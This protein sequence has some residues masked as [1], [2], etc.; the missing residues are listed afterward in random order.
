MHQDIFGIVNILFQVI[1]LPAEITCYIHILSVIKKMDHSYCQC[2]DGVL[3]PDTLTISCAMVSD[4]R[5][6]VLYCFCT[7]KEL[8]GVQLAGTT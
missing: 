6:S 8:P 2:V 5:T 3:E 1:I 7:T 4:L